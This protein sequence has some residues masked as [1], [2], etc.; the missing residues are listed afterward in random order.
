MTSSSVSRSPSTSAWISALV[1]S[2]LGHAA[3]LVDHRLVV[4]DQ[5][6]R[7]V[8][9]RRRDVVDAVLAVHDE[10]GLA[11]YLRAVLLGDAHHLGDDVHREL[12]GEVGD[13]VE[14][15]AVAAQLETLGQIA[16]G[17]LL[18]ARQQVVD[19]ARGE[20]A[21][22]EGAQPVL[23]GR[24]HA[25]DRH[26]LVGVGSPGRLLDRDAVGVGVGAVGPQR[27]GDVGVPRQRPEVERRVV[28]ERLVLAQPGVRRVGV[29]LE[30]VVV[31]VERDGCLG[32]GHAL[33]LR[34]VAM[35]AS[36]R[37]GSSS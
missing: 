35:T 37:S 22:D 8:H 31:G 33:P 9:R 5:P 11:A 34:I 28:V 23:A 29:L 7:G 18:D 10:V 20:A 14:L 16:V 26:H 32:R 21:R 1:R 15:P 3:A 24:V 30:R 2:S 19:P 4:G 17:E 13:P 12:A 25:E 27:L 36:S 6:E